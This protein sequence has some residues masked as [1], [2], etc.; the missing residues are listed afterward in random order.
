MVV[1]GWLDGAMSLNVSASD[2][3]GRPETTVASLPPK[4]PDEVT[5]LD[6]REEHEWVAGHAPDALHVPLGQLPDRQ[7]EVVAAAGSGQL[8]VTCH[9][10][11]RSARATDFLVSSGVNAVNLAGGMQQWAAAGRPLVS[12]TGAAPQVD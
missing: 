12:E 8:L 1:D 4:L 11:G 10:G 9:L 2:P 3:E 7:A 5:L 6:V